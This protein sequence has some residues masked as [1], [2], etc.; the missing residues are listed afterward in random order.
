MRNNIVFDLFSDSKAT[1]IMK[2]CNYFR[3]PQLAV[4]KSLKYGCSAESFIN[5]LKID[6]SAVDSS[7]VSIIGRHVTT[8]TEEEISSFS[9]NGL[10]DLRLSLQEQ[11]PLSLFL[12]KHH[13]QVNVDK[14]QLHLGKKVIP[15][16]GEKHSDHICFM[17]R[18]S[19]CSWYSGCETFQKLGV[20]HSK[21]Y[22]LGATLEFFVGGTID[23]MLNYSTVSHCPEILD[24]IDQI[25]SSIKNP[26]GRCMFPLCHEWASLYRNCYIIEFESVLSDMD[27]YNP[28]SYLEAYSQI[29]G[30]FTYSS[31]T[32][33]D[34]YER[35]IPQRVFDNKYL[36]ERIIDIYVYGYGEQ[37][38]SLQPGLSIKPDAIKIYSV[39]ND[40]LVA[41]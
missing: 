24:T 36:I 29:K 28:I 27:T 34:Y 30:C 31:V 3:L 38:G 40:Q 16:E 5:E 17:G 11:T 10:F 39:Q 14:H 33:N 21:L 32:Y 7:D 12:A 25:I 35:R 20:L 4:E 15:I 13:I 26:Y 6:L 41:L 23:E 18:D 37:Y 22:S 19:I 8:S 9:R 1:A 2:L